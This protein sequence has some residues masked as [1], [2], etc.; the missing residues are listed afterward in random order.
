MAGLAA[1]VALVA[2]ALPQHPF[3][4]R[5]PAQGSDLGAAPV[6]YPAGATA[7]LQRTGFRGRLVTSF[8]N[9]GFVIWKLYPAARVSFD[10]RYEVAYPFEALGEDQTIHGA[11]PGWQQ[12]LARYAGDAVLVQRDEPLARALPDATG[13]TRVYR[14]DAYDVWARPDLRLPAT[15]ASGAPVPVTFP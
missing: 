10:G 5:L 9:G 12:L 6:V 1:G 11:R 14:D 13:L 3:T 4:L 15:D 7:Y 2:V 8:V